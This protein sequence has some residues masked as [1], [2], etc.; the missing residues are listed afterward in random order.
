MPPDPD[1]VSLSIMSPIEVLY[2][3]SRIV[4][5]DLLIVDSE[6][7]GLKGPEGPWIPFVKSSLVSLGNLADLEGP[8]RSLYRDHPALA[9]QMKTISDDLA[10]AKY[11]RNVFG[12]HINPGVI[13]KAYEWRPELRKL[14]QIR[15]IAGTA[16]LNVYVLETAINT[17]VAPDGSHG[18]FTS[19]TDLLYPPDMER[20]CAW[21]STAVRT[22]IKV[23]DSLGRITHETVVPLGDEL[24]TL[25]AFKQAGLTDFNRIR[26]PR[27]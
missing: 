27:P 14:P 12:G 11:L 4:H 21:L 23:C 1:L 13:A 20:F 5:G 2:F 6:L 25:D 9:Q 24:E 26:R 22:A 7:T 8:M 18:M 10:F 19:E 3:Q 17:Y 16:M 15:E